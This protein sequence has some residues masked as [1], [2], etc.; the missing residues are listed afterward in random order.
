MVDISDLIVIIAG[1]GTPE[2]DVTGDNMTN[3]E[4]LL[5]VI[6]AFGPCP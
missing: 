3:V 4:D 6:G 2:A 5:I 1:W